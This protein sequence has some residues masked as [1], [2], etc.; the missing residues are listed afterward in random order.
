MYYPSFTEDEDVIKI[1]NYKRIGEWSQDVVH[2]PHESGWSISQAKG[3]DQPLK[4]TF[5]GLE[6]GLPY[7]CMFYQDLVVAK[8]QINLT[9][10]FGPC[11]LIKEVIDLGNLVPVSDCDF[12]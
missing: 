6:S 3:H 11:E 5:L 1:Y 2:H 7:I 8:H 12:S 10:V 4:N 9:E